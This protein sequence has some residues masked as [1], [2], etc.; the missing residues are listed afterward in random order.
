MTYLLLDEPLGVVELDQV[1]HIGIPQTVQI[2]LHRQTG[3]GSSSLEG[4]VQPTKGDPAA[5]LRHPQRR[6][7]TGTV[8]H[9]R[10]TAAGGTTWTAPSTVTSDPGATMVA[11]GRH[12]DG[13]VDTFAIFGDGFLNHAAQTSAGSASYSAFASI[14]NDTLIRSISASV[15]NADEIDLIAV[16]ASGRVLES[17]ETGPATNTWPAFTEIGSA[18]TIQSSTRLRRWASP[19]SVETSPLR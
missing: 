18:G 19:R 17:I 10:Q 6:V 12:H 14:P 4:L 13:R 9:I 2:Q 16:D 5:P 15:N 8:W 11:A 1:R 3:G 7:L